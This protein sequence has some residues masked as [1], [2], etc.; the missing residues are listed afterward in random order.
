MNRA[1]AYKTRKVLVPPGDS[2]S[3]S[4]LITST[5]IG[6]INLRVKAV[7]AIAGDSVIRTLLIKPEGDVMYR[8]E[9]RLIDLERKKEF[10]ERINISLPA[11]QI[12]GS[13]FLTVSLI[14]DLIG[15]SLNNLNGNFFNI[16]F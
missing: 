5:K 3:V 14:G 1:F 6:A 4:F 11:K 16:V 13:G 12:S 10:V 9:A 8:N 2:V 15:Y 7:S